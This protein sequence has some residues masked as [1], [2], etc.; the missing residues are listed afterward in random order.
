MP[1]PL[2]E[3]G[4]FEYGYLLGYM[5]AMEYDENTVQP[6]AGCRLGIQDGIADRAHMSEDDCAEMARICDERMQKMLHGN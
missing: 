3:Q 2:D 1:R 5:L 6:S 4:R